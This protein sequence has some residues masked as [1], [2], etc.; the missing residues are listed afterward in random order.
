MSQQQQNDDDI[1]RIFTLDQINQVIQNPGSDSVGGCGEGSPSS[2][3]SSSS[4][5][6]CFEDKLLVAMEYGFEQFEKNLFYAAPIQ[7]LGLRPYPFSIINSSSANGHDGDSGGRDEEEEA[8]NAA[9]AKK[10]REYTSQTCVKSG[11]FLNNKYYVIKVATGGT[12]FPSNWGCMQVYS[13]YDGKLQA[14]L[15]DHGI[16]TEI[17]TACVG[18]LAAKYLAP[19]NTTRP[20]VRKIGILG[21]GIQARYQLHYLQKV[22][23]NVVP[24]N[25][26]QVDVIIWGR[27]PNKVNKLIEEIL[28][29]KKTSSEAPFWNSITS[30]PHPNDLL[31][32][33]ELIITTT[34]STKPLLGVTTTNDDNGDGD[35]NKYSESSDFW[36]QF[37]RKIK[38]DGLHITCI[39]SDAPGKCE[40][41]PTFIKRYGDLCVADTLEQSQ[42]RGEFQYILQDNDTSDQDSKNTTTP[43][44][45]SLGE[46]LLDK[47]TYQRR[48]END[49]RVTIFDSSGVALQDCII[50]E[51]TYEALLEMKATRTTTRTTT[52]ANS[53]N[54]RQKTST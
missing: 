2:S 38:Q 4:P 9:D 3:S 36:K 11:Y 39:G 18:A 54:K 14:I 40:V 1:P 23:K 27:N 41:C 15:L 44:F 53:S 50:S 25:I 51:I 30:V 16:L 33:C 22:H 48:P 6:L 46:L 35:N 52:T 7:T 13:Q 43:K 49:H 12:P 45:I 34:S 8:G 29:E 21:C 31:L 32:E 17:R 26:N 42:T 24:T 10:K 19:Q 47:S 20:H 28:Q 5:S 37:E